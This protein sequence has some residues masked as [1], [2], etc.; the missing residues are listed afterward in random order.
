M[1]AAYLLFCKGDQ[2]I[3][4]SNVSENEI[5]FLKLNLIK[6]RFAEVNVMITIEA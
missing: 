3:F 6:D 2:W 1:G 5:A 4:L